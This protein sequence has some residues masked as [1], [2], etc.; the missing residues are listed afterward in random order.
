ML[1]YA[2]AIQPLILCLKDPSSYQ[3]N[4]YV[5][6]SAYG[7]CL[8]Q[9]K[10][11]F[12]LLLQTGPSYDYFAELSKSVLL[13]K[14]QHFEEAHRVFFDLEVEVSST[15]CRF[16]GGYVGRE[17]DV[18]EYVRQRVEAWVKRV[19]CLASAVRA[20]PQSAYAAF[21]CS[22]SCEWMYM[23]RVCGGIHQR[24]TN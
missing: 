11:W 22:L 7:G 24:P 17:V 3:Q 21:T 2:V 19:E 9:L 15:C 16:L 14:E 18:H 10:S 4:W 12:L 13:V 6:D 8:A 20:Y 5:V 23:Q 1:M